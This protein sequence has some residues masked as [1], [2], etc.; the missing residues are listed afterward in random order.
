MGHT[1][2]ILLGFMVTIFYRFIVV[3]SNSPSRGSAC[4]DDPRDVSSRDVV[5]ALA[6]YNGMVQCVVASPINKD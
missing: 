6:L 5:E 3:R 4:D 1:N 2:R